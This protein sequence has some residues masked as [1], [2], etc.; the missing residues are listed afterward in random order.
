MTGMKAENTK[1][2]SLWGKP[3][4][5]DIEVNT[6]IEDIKSNKDPILEIGLDLIQ[7]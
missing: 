6:T 5:P 3:I 7:K 1:G 4:I 2:G